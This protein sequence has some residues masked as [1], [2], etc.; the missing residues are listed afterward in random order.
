M[1]EQE[2]PRNQVGPVVALV[3]ILALLIIGAIYYFNKQQRTRTEPPSALVR[4]QQ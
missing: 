2:E 3:L 4:I 1:S